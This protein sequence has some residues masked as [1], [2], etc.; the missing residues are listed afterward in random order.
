MG[1]VGVGF[2]EQRLLLWRY[3]SNWWYLVEKLE[4]YIYTFLFSFPEQAFNTVR[5]NKNRKYLEDNH[6]EIPYI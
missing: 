1:M 4:I 6:I 3:I 2:R 5:A